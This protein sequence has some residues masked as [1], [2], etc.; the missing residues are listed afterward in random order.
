MYYTVYRY[1]LWIPLIPSTT[2]HLTLNQPITSLHMPG[3]EISAEG[4][5]IKTTVKVWFSW[6]S[7]TRVHHWVIRL[8]CALLKKEKQI[9]PYLFLILKK[10]EPYLKNNV[11]PTFKNN[12]CPTLKK[13]LVPYF[14]KTTCAQFLKKTSVLLFPYFF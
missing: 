13:K 4:P 6:Q 10:L 12:L 14:L 1:W 2:F 5:S 7:S 9:V 8:T 3:E 11:R